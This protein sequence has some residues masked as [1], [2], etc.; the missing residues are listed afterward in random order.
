MAYCR[1]GE[2]LRGLGPRWWGG[3]LRQSESKKP[4]NIISSRRQQKKVSCFEQ[5]TTGFCLTLRHMIITPKTLAMHIPIRIWTLAAEMARWSSLMIV[6]LTSRF[7]SSTRPILIGLTVNQYLFPRDKSS[8]NIEHTRFS[9]V[10]YIFG[11]HFDI[12]RRLILIQTNSN[13]R[14]PPQFHFQSQDTAIFTA[15]KKSFY[16]P[17]LQVEHWKLGLARSRHLGPAT[18]A[19][20]IHTEKKIL[21]QKH[22][23]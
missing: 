1:W 15:H 22:E 12:L 13:S 19:T 20:R 16:Y 8:Q 21:P 14:H 18:P 11:I 6:I 3:Y 9:G 17:L 2:Y 5:G 10:L 23:E 7:L 4:R